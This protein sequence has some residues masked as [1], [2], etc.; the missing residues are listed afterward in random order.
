MSS[1]LS[2]LK[3]EA[4]FSYLALSLF[5]RKRNAGKFAPSLQESESS[6]EL[7]GPL[8]NFSCFPHGVFPRASAHGQGQRMEG[9][10]LRERDK[11]ARDLL[12]FL[13]TNCSGLRVGSTG[14][15]CRQGASD[16]LRLHPGGARGMEKQS[17][18]LEQWWGLA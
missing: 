10:G 1:F 4:L 8:W 6:W 7:T 11:C 14:L 17:N 3:H 13:M 18:V 15:P 9:V 12:A 5:G 16:F 2:A